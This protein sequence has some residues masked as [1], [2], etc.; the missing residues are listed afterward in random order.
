[1]P[2]VN[3]NDF[4]EQ[5]AGDCQKTSAAD[6]GIASVTLQAALDSAQADIMDALEGR[7]YSSDQINSGDRLAEFH[8]N[9]ALWRLYSKPGGFKRSYD[10]N[11]MRPA[12]RTAMLANP[13]YGWRVGGVIVWPASNLATLPSGTHGFARLTRPPDGALKTW[14]GLPRNPVTPWV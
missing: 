10:E 7:G 11:E 8:L 9:Q 14:D 4:T 5:V 13:Q 2:F 3:I 12:D 1:M 6:L